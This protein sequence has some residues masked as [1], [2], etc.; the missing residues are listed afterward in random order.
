[1]TTISKAYRAKSRVSRLSRL[2]GGAVPWPPKYG[3]I[4]SGPAEVSG[5]LNLRG[6]CLQIQ[7]SPGSGFRP[8]KLVDASPRS[9]LSSVENRWGQNHFFII[10]EERFGPSWVRV[11]AKRIRL[12]LLRA[13]RGPQRPRWARRR[14]LPGP[15]AGKWAKAPQRGAN[16][17]I[18]H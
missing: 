14:P 10:R 9:A 8:L 13:F 5:Q 3:D 17:L 7:R 12:S 6:N 15:K 16:A 11:K 4:I 2:E 1:M 18:G